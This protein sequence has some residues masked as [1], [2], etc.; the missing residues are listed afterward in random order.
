MKILK[1]RSFLRIKI[2]IEI[3]LSPFC[4]PHC[5]AW[6]TQLWRPLVYTIQ[7]GGWLKLSGDANFDMGNSI[8]K[9]VWISR[10]TVIS[11][12]WH[13]R[14]NMRLWSQMWN[15]H[16]VTLSEVQLSYINW[17]TINRSLFVSILFLRDGAVHKLQALILSEL[18]GGVFERFRYLGSSSDLESPTVAE[19]GLWNYRSWLHYFLKS[20]YSG[21]DLT[22]ETVCKIWIIIPP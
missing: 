4:I 11:V 21:K 9:K 17:L 12:K 1:N 6:W 5:V 18:Y 7:I 19:H 20:I 15:N 2:I 16:R 14:E 10:F 8:I 3:Q 22:S 13:K